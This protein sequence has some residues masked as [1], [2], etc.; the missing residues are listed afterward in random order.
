MIQAANVGIGLAGKEGRQAVNNSDYSISQFRFLVRLL[1]VHGQLSHYRIARLIKYSFYK[2]IA[3]AFILIYYQFF[4]GFSGQPLIDDIS[5]AMYNVVFTSVPILLFA[6]VDRPLSDESLIRFPQLYNRSQSLS[7]K[8]FW[9]SGI[10]DGLLDATICF[11]IPVFA[12]T[13]AGR[14]STHGLWS[15]GKTAYVALLG[16][17]TLEMAL[18]TR[19]WTMVFFIF[20][21]LSYFL[22]YPFFLIFPYA[23]R[24][25]DIFD[26]AQF[27]V[28]E[29]LFATSSFWLTIVA[30][31]A[32]TFG[33][34]YL[35][36]TIKWLYYPD[37]NM[38][39]AE[40]EKKCGPDGPLAGLGANEFEA[41][42]MLQLG[43]GERVRVEESTQ[44]IQGSKHTAKGVVPPEIKEQQA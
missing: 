14:D 41:Q 18:V 44:G 35:S 29:N 11:F 34:R 5:A 19:Y 22:V 17:V 24:L 10:L 1:L 16:A 20:M 6:L 9:K 23:E 4:N 42:R 39:I 27:G 12:A 3:F 38:I 25:F 32:A 36:R 30:V 7:T 15:V 31:Y 26:P 8:V 2:N 37:D 40:F 28:A 33:Y 13:P 21:L 43:Y